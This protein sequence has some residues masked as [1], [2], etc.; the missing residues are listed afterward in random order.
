MILVEK[1]LNTPCYIIS[2]EKFEKN[3]KLF[4]NKFAEHMEG[5]IPLLGYSVKTNHASELMKCALSAGMAAE[6]VSDDEYY[7]ALNCGFKADNIIYN[8]PQKSEKTLI[9]ALKSGSIVNLDNFDEIEMIKKNISQ[10]E[11]DSLKLGIRVNFD[12]EALCPGETTAREVVSRFGFCVENGDFDRAV[13]MLQEMG[14]T[15]RGIH[16]HYS[17]TSRSTLIYKEL[18]AMAGQMIEK[19]FMDISG[20]FVDMGGGFFLGEQENTPGKP[21]LDE[22]AKMISGE[23]KKY[24]PLENIRMILEP[25]ASIIATSVKYLTKVLNERIVRDSK[26]LTLDGSILHI[27]PFMSKR[28]PA[29]KVIYSNERRENIDK[30]ILCGSTCMENDRFLEIDCDKEIKKGD[31]LLCNLAGAYTMGFNSCFINLPP[32]IYVEENQ[33]YRMTRGKE[34]DL[35]RKI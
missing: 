27:N 2:K 5:K 29:A 16:M 19:Y 28:Y 1:K 11:L 10:L 17:S 8:G 9:W 33:E 34:P 21:T 35:M 7:H 26:V 23:L 3:I 18:S 12:L 25:G 24:V 20:F 15:V 30:Q 4:E 31:Y 32:Y 13:V 14:I 6:V 22:Y